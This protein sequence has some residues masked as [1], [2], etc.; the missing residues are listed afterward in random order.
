MCIILPVS[1]CH[2]LITGIGTTVANLRAANTK[3]W[4]FPMS[5]ADPDDT[6]ELLRFARDVYA[7]PGLQALCLRLQDEHQIDVVLLLTCCWY[8]CYCGEMSDTQLAR[9]AGFADQ[10]RA[11]LVSPLRQARRWLK[12]H[13]ASAAGIPAEQ[14][15]ALRRRIKALELDAEFMQL[16]ALAA[17]FNEPAAATQCSVAQATASI[18]ANLLRYCQQ[19]GTAGLCET[20]LATLLQACLLRR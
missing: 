11:Q 13:P 9:A 17:L 5:K 3:I 14:Q 6:R 7:E 20:D 1:Y 19:I 10:W 12:P 8:G 15:E 18:R 4:R 16:R 2:G